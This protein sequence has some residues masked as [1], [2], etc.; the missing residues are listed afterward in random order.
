[1]V[2]GVVS[3]FA[4]LLLL[5]VTL[6]AFGH[7]EAER[8]ALER[9]RFETKQRTAAEEGLR[10]AQKMEGI[11]QLTGGVAHDFNNLLAVILGNLRL[12]TKQVSLTQPAQR[13]LDGA[14]QG[15]ERGA[16]LTQRL[17]AFARRQ[18]LMPRTI[19]IGQLLEDM[20]EL[21]RQSIGAEV[22]L[23]IDVEPGLPTVMADAN[24]LELAMLNLV[25][26]ARDAMPDG[27]S[28]AISAREA[29]AEEGK[30]TQVRISV[31][32]SGVGMD[33]ETLA[34]A[35]EPFFTTKG[36]GKGTG[37]GLAMVHGF[38]AQSGGSLK[39][40]SRKGEGAVASLFLPISLE[41]PA[42]A[43]APSAAAPDAPARPLNLL[44][45]DDDAL[46]MM[47]TAA[48]LEDLGHTVRE[49]SSGAEAL[50]ALESEPA[51]DLVV[52]DQSMPGM[53]G[54]ELARRIRD[55]RPG[56]PVLIA[57]GHAELPP[58][59]AKTLPLL[60]KPFTQE[61]LQRALQDALSRA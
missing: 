6:T 51:F 27:G 8:V 3:A 41:R 56:M 31:A 35:V 47:G 18:D 4:A 37:M 10:Q 59:E 46:V 53:T 11:G 14:I 42:P 7:A 50:E 52:T 30:A 34:R 15:A 57:S 2:F 19:D 28:I 1:L 44:L 5:G 12:L 39:L 16:F 29:P 61:Q 21:M 13:L 23:T 32:D 38:A 33:E 45:V 26:N 49:C 48:M 40:T 24:Q 22:T 60:T 58:L 20:T 43:Q 36:V 55:A 25:I 17:L 54:L 9:L